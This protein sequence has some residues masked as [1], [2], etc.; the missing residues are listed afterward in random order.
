MMIS[1][2]G[3]NSYKYVSELDFKFVIIPLFGL[4]EFRFDVDN[5]LKARI[6]LLAKHA[7]DNN[8]DL[9]IETNLTGS[10]TLGFLSKLQ[11]K[12]VGVVY[13]VGNATGC[14]HKVEHDLDILSEVISHIHIKDKNLF[15]ENVPLGE[16]I[17]NFTS[18]FNI[19][20]NNNYEGDF[21]LETNRGKI[22][23][24]TTINNMNYIRKFF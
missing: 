6:S 10:D 22:A 4:S 15:G 12:N 24:S 19:L 13:D 1:W 9:L 7:N 11:N 20:K 3:C 5:Q 8:I 2:E 18:I 21:T 23:L 17:V 16:G 14:G